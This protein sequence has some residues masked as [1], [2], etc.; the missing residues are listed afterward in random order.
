MP[1]SQNVTGSPSRRRLIKA[2]FAG[3]AAPAVLRIGAAFAAYPDRPIRI[4]VANTPGGP[5]DIIAR[6]MAAAMQETMGGSVVVENKGGGGGN[7]GMGYVARAEADG[8]TILLST[9]AYSVN[10]GLYNTLSYD[11]FRDFTAICELAVSPHVFAVKP[12]LG[13]GTMKEFVA[14]A[15]ADPDRF[16][17]S[18]PPIGTT[19]QL[20]AEVLKLRE[21]LQK[22]ATVVFAGGG[23]ALKAGYIV[24]GQV[25]RDGERVRVLAHLIR[26]P[27]QTHLWV[28]RVEA[29]P[30]ELSTPA[31]L[32]ERISTEFLRKL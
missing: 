25:Q 27:E 15:K 12:D 6:I 29:A 10:P 2:A 32:A 13:V 24:I 14:R 18:T 5:S 3:L 21:G 7:I 19:P 26:L 1:Q 8:Y 4:V 28:T 31:G 22:M 17:V 20:Q 23:D 9:S 16:N 30:S 11:P